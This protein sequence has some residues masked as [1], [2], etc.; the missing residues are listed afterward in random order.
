[1]LKIGKAYSARLSDVKIHFAVLDA[2]ELTWTID[3][4]AI[5]GYFPGIEEGINFV[6][7]KSPFMRDAI[8]Y[9]LEQINDYEPEHLDDL[10][11]LSLDLKNEELF[12]QLAREKQETEAVK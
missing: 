4:V 7:K 1:M 2:D 11:D 9:D 10:I 6:N 5:R 8:I 12:Y 3:I